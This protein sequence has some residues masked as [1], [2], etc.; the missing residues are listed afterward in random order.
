MHTSGTRLTMSAKKPSTRKSHA[1]TLILSGATEPTEQ[2]ENALFDAHCDDSLLGSRD[3]VL[4]LEFDREADSLREAVLSAITAIEGADVG[5]RVERAEAEDDESSQT[6]Q[7]SIGDSHSCGIL[8]SRDKNEE[9]NRGMQRRVGCNVTAL[10]W[11]RCEQPR[12][13]PDDDQPRCAGSDVAFPDAVYTSV[14]TLENAPNTIIFSHFSGSPGATLD[15]ESLL[16]MSFCSQQIGIEMSLRK[17]IRK[18]RGMSAPGFSHS[19]SASRCSLSQA[20]HNCT[21]PALG[22]RTLPHAF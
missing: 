13:I 8:T 16:R 1:F 19:L 12:R 17:A 7:K 14:Q 15:P 5:L 10:G 21:Q 9:A 18:P 2:I 6:L 4:F 3:G 22:G 11:R 20:A